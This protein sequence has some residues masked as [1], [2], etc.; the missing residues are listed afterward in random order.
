MKVQ[1]KDT[2]SPLDARRYAGVVTVMGD[3][4]DGAEGGGKKR[5]KI[6]LQEQPKRI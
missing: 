6:K 1:D 4:G 5:R 3:T 2:A